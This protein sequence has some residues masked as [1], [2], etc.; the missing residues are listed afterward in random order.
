MSFS[1]PVLLLYTKPIGEGRIIVAA[2]G[3]EM[4]WKGAG[5]AGFMVPQRGVEP[6]T[7]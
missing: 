1:A 4:K 2:S 5:P 6:P 7:C 3:N